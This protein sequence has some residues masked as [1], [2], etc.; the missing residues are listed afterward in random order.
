MSKQSIY[1]Y[2]G[3]WGEF[4]GTPGQGTFLTW[5]DADRAAELSRENPNTIFIV[6]SKGD[7]LSAWSRGYLLSRP[8]FRING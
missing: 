8:E 1:T 6:Y 7:W 5:G 2:S 3:N 4:R